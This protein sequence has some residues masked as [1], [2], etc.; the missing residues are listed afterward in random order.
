MRRSGRIPKS[1]PLLLLFL[2]GAGTVWLRGEDLLRAEE[3]EKQGRLEEAGALYA[4]WLAREENQNS[5]SY[6]RTLLHRLRMG[7]PAEEVLDLLDAHVSQVRN[8]QDKR[9]L[10]QFGGYLADLAGQPLRAAAY[11]SALSFPDRERADWIAAYYRFLRGDPGLPEDPLTLPAR[12]MDPQLLKSSALVYLLALSRRAEQGAFRSW[13]GRAERQFPFLKNS[14]DW[15]FLAAFSYER[16]GESE[17][18]EGYRRSLEEGFPQSPEAAILEG[19]LRLLSSPA[20]LLLPDAA[21]A[22][23]TAPPAV[24]AAETAP[25][26]EVPQAAE[27][28]RLVYLQAGVFSSRRNAEAL[29]RELAERSGLPAAVFPAGVAYRVLIPT[30]KPA[31]ETRRLKILGY[32]VFRTNPPESR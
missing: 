27:P 18:S 17:R 23:E 5:P 26:A 24:P 7:G 3:L 16:R 4:R 29:R 28:S 22:E 30:E 31:E 9:E 19:R 25:P 8:E 20:Y 21:P 6:G 14:P 15:L 13:V 1:L 10:L 11:F 12:G 32:E 2:L